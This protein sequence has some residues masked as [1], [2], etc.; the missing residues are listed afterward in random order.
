M[1][2]CPDLGHLVSL[3][4]LLPEADIVGADDVWISGCTSDSRQ[5]RDG[6]LFAA[7][8]GSRRDGHDFAAEAVARAAARPCLQSGR[9][10]SFQSPRA[11]FP[12]PAR[13]L[14]GS[15]RRWPAIQAGS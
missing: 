6:E 5:V 10:P 15:V 11:L 12:T 1:Q 4:G 8:T 2:V 14:P 3:R 13:R 7:L 9:F